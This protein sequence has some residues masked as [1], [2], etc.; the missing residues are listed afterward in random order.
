MFKLKLGTNFAIF[1]L[2]FGIATI[3]AIQTKNWIKV[4]FWVAISLV[5]LFADNIKKN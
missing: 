5:F 2:F 1:I 3:E 4:A